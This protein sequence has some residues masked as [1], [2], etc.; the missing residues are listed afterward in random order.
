L[1]HRAG[2]SEGARVWREPR[3]RLVCEAWGADPRIAAEVG[4][5][6]RWYSGIRDGEV[7]RRSSGG[8]SEKRLGCVWVG[9]AEVHWPTTPPIRGKRGGGDGEGGTP[10]RVSGGAGC[11]VAK[12][13]TGNTR[14]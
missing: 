11:G 14:E 6:S 1:I 12:S 8:R 3:L 9:E 5:A 13:N 7:P 4:W 2:D 10:V